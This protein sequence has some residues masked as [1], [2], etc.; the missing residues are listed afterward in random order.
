MAK[1]RAREADGAADKM[2]VDGGAES[3]DEEVQP[4]TSH[5]HTHILFN[6]S[7][8][9]PLAP[10]RERSHQTRGIGVRGLEYPERPDRLT[11][12]FLPP[13]LGL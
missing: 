12:L 3:S 1:K 5:T 13:F 10:G 2:A 9:L 4:A 11:F 7:Y 8:T 6:L